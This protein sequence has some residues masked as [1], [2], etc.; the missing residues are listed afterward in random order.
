M[1]LTKTQLHRIFA[2]LHNNHHSLQGRQIPN[3]NRK[4][5]RKTNVRQAVTPAERLTLT[6]R[7]LPTGVHAGWSS[8]L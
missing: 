2:A 6:Q 7:Y 5:L 4:T 3:K 8:G 1:G